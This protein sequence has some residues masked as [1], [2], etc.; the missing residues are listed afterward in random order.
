MSRSQQAIRIT[1]PLTDGAIEKLSVGDR[2]LINGAVYTARDAAHLRLIQTLQQ[3][4]TLPI[5]IKRQIIYYVG[6]SPAIPG[7]PIG[8]AGPTTSYRMD[9]YTPKLLEQGLRGMIGKGARSREVREA[10]K[11]FE[12]IYFAAIG[13]AGALISSCIESAEVVA[14]EDLGP[15]A[16]H[17]CVVRDFPAI[18][19]ND[20][21]GG[22]IY[23][24]RRTRFY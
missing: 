16:V 10:I 7:K 13:G 18:V 1:T 20:A 2:V 12:A 14:Y 24:N 5:N 3:K 21:K 11:K 19:A 4:E 22:D 23:K 6:P 17:R 15:E 8:S 9:T